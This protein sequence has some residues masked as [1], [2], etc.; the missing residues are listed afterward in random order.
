MDTS[1]KP[2]HQGI[3][4]PLDHAEA[5]KWFKKGADLGNAMSAVSQLNTWWY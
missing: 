2:N 4:V 3:G 1:R 5:F